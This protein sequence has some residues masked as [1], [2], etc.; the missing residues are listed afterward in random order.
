MNNQMPASI[1][2]P[3][4]DIISKALL[5]FSEQKISLFADQLIEQE[6]GGSYE[7]IRERIIKWSGTT[8]EKLIA[9][10]DPAWI[11]KRIEKTIQDI[12]STRKV[13]PEV[14][15]E[16]MK[17][18]ELAGGGK[19]FVINYHFYDTL[20]GR[21]IMASTAKGICFLAFSDKDDKEALDK[22]KQRFPRAEYQPANDKFQSNALSLFDSG[23]EPTPVINLHVKGTPFQIKTWKKL[24]QIPSGGLM[25]YGALADN[26]KYSHALGAAVGANPVAY[27][28][29]CHRTVPVTGKFGEYHWGSGRKAALISWEAAQREQPYQSRN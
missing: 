20:F 7:S 10:L 23:T 21:I 1:N 22:L 15:I 11:K 8:P 24:L 3:D 26:P 6:L 16:N 17:A 25:S 13:T 12:K 29:P 18:D 9:Y 2:Q 4:F 14:Q 5:F 28:I 27:V 19:G